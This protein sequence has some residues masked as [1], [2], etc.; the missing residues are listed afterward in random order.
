MLG[1]VFVVENTQNQEFHIL[2]EENPPTRNYYRTIKHGLVALAKLY[3]FL[4]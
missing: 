4:A 1:W 2:S 3:T